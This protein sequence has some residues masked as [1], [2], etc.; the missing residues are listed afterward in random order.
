MGQAAGLAVNDEVFVGRGATAAINAE[1]I[2]GGV[3]PALREAGAGRPLVTTASLAE[4][5]ADSVGRVV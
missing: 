4:G 3:D 2:G 1:E 5:S